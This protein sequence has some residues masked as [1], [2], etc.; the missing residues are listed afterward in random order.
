MT[1]SEA[2]IELLLFELNRI[3]SNKIKNDVDTVNRNSKSII[4]AKNR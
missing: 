2:H 4:N 3:W 1:I